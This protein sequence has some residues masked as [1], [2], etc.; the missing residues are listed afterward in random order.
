VYVSRKRCFSGNRDAIDARELLINSN[1]GFWVFRL[2]RDRAN[3]HRAPRIHGCAI[4]GNH[5]GL[6]VQQLLLYTVRPSRFL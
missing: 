3:A 1:V 5:Q 2:L 4:V 6:T